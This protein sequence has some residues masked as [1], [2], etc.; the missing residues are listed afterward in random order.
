MKTIA[1]AFLLLCSFSPAIGQSKVGSSIPT[2]E[3][4]LQRVDEKAPY[5]LSVAVNEVEITFHA[6]DAGHHPVL[7]LRPEELDVFDTGSGPGQIVSLRQLTGRPVHAKFIIDTSGSVAPQIA[8]ARAEAQEAVQKLV[9]ESADEGSTVEFGRSRHLVQDWTNQRESL[10][11]SI[12]GIGTKPFDPIDGTSVYDTLLSTC[13]YEFGG[14]SGAPAAHVIL[15]FSDG[16][17][18]SSHATLQAAIDSCRTSKTVLYA[19]SPRPAPGAHSL[20]PST[21]R[22]LTEETG[23]RLFYVSDSNGD[24]NADLETVASDVGHEYVLIYKPKTLNHDGAFHGIVLVGPKRVADIV[25]TSGFYA[26]RR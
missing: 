10:L 5:S 7:D 8:R 23:G 3:A 15:L 4:G 6:A 11:R 24:L 2:A 17:D 21:L 14:A 9:V 18:T 1:M 16:V 19:F 26:P 12:G 22:H 20:G 13:L 25:G